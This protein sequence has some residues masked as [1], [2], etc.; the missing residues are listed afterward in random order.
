MRVRNKIETIQTRWREIDYG[1]TIYTPGTFLALHI[2]EGKN[3]TKYCFDMAFRPYR[4]RFRVTLLKK[5]TAEPAYNRLQ[6]NN[7]F[8]Q[9]D[10]KSTTRGVE[11]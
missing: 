8:C 11:Y 2:Q 1:G 3:R 4:E 9:L 7:N 6:G 10:K 5:Y